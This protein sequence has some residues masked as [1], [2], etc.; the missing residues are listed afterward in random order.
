MYKKIS[1]NRK[2]YTDSFETVEAVKFEGF[3]RFDFYDN[4]NKSNTAKTMYLKS[5][6]LNYDTYTVETLNPNLNCNPLTK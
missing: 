5:E 6:W 2:N 3:Y 4:D 1:G